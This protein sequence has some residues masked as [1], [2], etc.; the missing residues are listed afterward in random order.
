MVTEGSLRDATSS[1]Q[2]Y[3]ADVSHDQV[4]SLCP[5]RLRRRFGGRPSGPSGPSGI[6]RRRERRRRAAPRGPGGRGPHRKRERRHDQRRPSL[7][8][9]RARRRGNPPRQARQRRLALGHGGDGLDG[10]HGSCGR[11]RGPPGSRLNVGDISRRRG[12]RARP[13]RSHRAGR[14]VDL[15]FYLR[16]TEGDEEV[17]SDRFVSLARSGRGR[18]HGRTYS[19]DVARNWA[20]MRSILENPDVAVQY[21]LVTPSLRRLLL[22]HAR[23][24]GADSGLIQRFGEVSARRGGSASHRSHFHVRIFCS[25]GDRPRCVNAPPFHPWVFTTASQVEKATREYREFRPPRRARSRRSRRRG[26][27]RRRGMM[28]RSMMRSSGMSMANR[29]MANR[30]MA[31]RSMANRSMT[32]RSMASRAAMDSATSP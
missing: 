11:R 26:R 13:H 21:V 8:L 1:G 16:D 3:P 29:S 24:T 22:R 10:R 2:D 23:A 5:R 7:E 17:Q 30:S 14:D 28:Q 4:G 19:F 25:N 31:S 18:N 6:R 12:G 32:S 15:G 9:R 20:L 27:M